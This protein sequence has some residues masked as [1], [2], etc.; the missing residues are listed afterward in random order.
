MLMVNFHCSYMSRHLYK[1]LDT[2]RIDKGW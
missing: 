2:A 1:L